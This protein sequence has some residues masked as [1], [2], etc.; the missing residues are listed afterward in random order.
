MN[1]LTLPAKYL[2][3]DQHRLLGGW[4]DIVDDI[5]ALCRMLAELPDVC[6][7]GNGTS[8][9][10]G[11][12]PCC[13]TAV[14]D[15]VPSCGD[16]D[17]QL[18]RLRPAMDMLTVDSFRFFP[19]LD[20]VLAHAAIADAIR[21][22]HEIEIHIAAVVRSFGTLVVAADQFRANC[23]M[24]HLETLKEAATGLLRE[25]ELLNRVL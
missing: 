22:A 10:Q 16:C 11:R 1:N 20:D 25:A 24:S 14:T 13:H 17:A 12:C 4:R 21:G 18:A 6:Q 15:R 9:L 5:R 23:R 19:A 3:A 8:H 7:C 2:S